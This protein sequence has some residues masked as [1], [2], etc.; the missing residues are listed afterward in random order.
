[1]LESLS[2]S[3]GP[4]VGDSAPAHRAVKIALLDYEAVGGRYGRESSGETF[5]CDRVVFTERE[6]APTAAPLT[7][8]LE[9]LFSLDQT[10]VAGWQNFIARTNETLS[11]KRARVEQSTGLAHIHL[12]GRLSG[13]GGVCDNPRA[14]TQIV[15]TA[16][17]FPSVEKVQLY[18]NGEPTDLQPSG[19]GG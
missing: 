13:L 4:P 7:A 9:E 18:L 14:R 2:F 16:L 3:A 10:S 12:S 15:Q 6:I 5:G 11:F 17:Q 19:R 8:A 1:M